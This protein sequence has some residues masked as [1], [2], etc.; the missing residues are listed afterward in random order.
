M[1][2]E[3]KAIKFCL[4]G[5]WEK[6]IE[7]NT[8][9]VNQDPQ[10]INALNRLARSWANFGK[11]GKARIYYNQVLKY[12]KYNSIAI[13]NLEILKNKKA[14]KKTTFSISENAFIEEPGK[15]KCVKLT[16]LASP[17]ILLELNAGEKINI[18]PKK[19]LISV[20]NE[21]SVYLGSISDDLSRYLIS[22]IKR[23]N[24]YEAFV[25]SVDKK[26][27]EIF[28]RELKRVKSLQN[29]P[30]FPSG[31][32]LYKSYLPPKKVYSDTPD[33]LTDEEKDENGLE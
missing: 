11:V 33:I 27:L 12:D 10:D 28:I 1:D 8:L 6:A 20:T 9:L 25:K 31:N 23:G 32:L 14:K 29:T 4:E 13:K 18:I 21:K 22:F 26:Q 3:K 7:Y 5:N 16:K 17:S 24:E 30:T 15:T 2:I 19:R